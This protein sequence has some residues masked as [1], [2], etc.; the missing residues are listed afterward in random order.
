MREIFKN[1]IKIFNK[2]FRDGVYPG[3]LFVIGNGSGE[4]LRHKIGYSSLIDKES[5]NWETRYD[6]ASLTKIVST[7]MV[8]LIL[9]EEKKLKLSDN[10]GEI[11]N[12][13]TDVKISNLMTHT[14]GIKAYY[15]L[16]Q[17]ENND[18]DF[19]IK[20][21]LNLERERKAGEE[22]IYSC[23]GYI[24][25]GR[26]LEKIENK[27]LNILAKKLIFE[28]LGMKDTSY[29]PIGK[30]FASTEKLTEDIVLN[31]I[32]HD[33][34]ARFLNGVSGNAGLFSNIEDMSIFSKMLSNCGENLLSK[35]IFMESI[36][37]HTV[38]LAENRGLGF[39]LWNEKDYPT[40]REFSREAYGHTGFTGTSIFV[41]R[42]TGLY[43]CILSNRV[44]LN[45]ENIKILKFRKYFHGVVM[46]EYKEKYKG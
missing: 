41:D 38:G 26:V 44:H 30:N 4:I 17:F 31:G 37:N 35:E 45:R 9:L 7:T 23:L 32:V 18:K 22:V 19:I 40:G 25:L 12:I 15:N 8:A 20:E 28:K 36:K 11:F 5:V 34:N 33:E 3:G 39:S 43:V 14:S 27:P 16:S 2:G 46:K 1:T 21:I 10:I 42:D 6:I 24:V 13:A 29:N